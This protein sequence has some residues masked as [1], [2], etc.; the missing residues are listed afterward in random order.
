MNPACLVLPV[1]CGLA[2]F[3]AAES[4]MLARTTSLALS[5][6][7]TI[8]FLLG[9]IWV[10]ATLIDRADA[11]RHQATQ[12]LRRSEL[13]YH[14]L[15]ETLPQNILRK[16]AEGRFTFC[17][18]RFCQTVGRERSMMI[19]KTDFDLFPQA[20][21]QKYR[22][23]DIR[24]MNEMK[25]MEMVESHI[26]P[27]GREHFVHVIKTPLLDG[28][29]NPIGVQGIF[30]DVTSER[31]RER[32][33]RDQ[34]EQ[35]QQMAES[36]RKAHEEL[37]RAQAQ[38][39]QT[40]KLVGLG[41]TVAGVAHE[42]N[43]PLAYVINN[44]VV[45]DRDISSIRDV[46]ARYREADPLLEAQAAKL[47]EEIRRLWEEADIDYTLANL[48]GLFERT[49]DGLGR[50]QRIVK[51]LR[52]FARVD[53]DRYNDADLN[54]GVVSTVHIVQGNAKARGVTIA[55]ELGE[56]PLLFC[57]SAKINQVILNLVSNAIEASSSGGQVTV[58]TFVDGDLIALDVHDRG[59]GIDPA[60][61]DRIFD[62]FFTTKPIGEGTGLGLSISYGIVTDH[63]GTIDAESMPETGTTFAV[64][65][66][67]RKEAT[68]SA[69]SRRS[70]PE[71]K[72][73][74]AAELAASTTGEGSR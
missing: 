39:V 62:P 38:M 13:F 3:L 69:E 44:L 6:L 74:P 34:N 21:A 50:I 23:D 40:A 26:T 58:R 51:D 67:M 15:V 45:L 70:H 5:V 47:C 37:K 20:L 29:M 63:D 73:E 59:C 19:G 46:L 18:D 10:N 71:P 24:V 9:L 32:R 41:Q 11:R 1:V 12:A 28:K 56:I 60:I 7:A 2:L 33:L 43:N 54:E 48:T 30:W 65:L 42:I 14:T 55:L 52:V 4:N 31:L 72:E 66:P 68:R 17:N 22:G 36:E 35:L 53:E 57:Q 49:R 8:L 16:D 25:T 27:D 61:K 64:P